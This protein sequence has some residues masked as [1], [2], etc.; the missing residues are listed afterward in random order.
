MIK[1]YENYVSDRSA[2]FEIGDF[3]AMTSCMVLF[4]CADNKAIFY[5]T[6]RSRRRRA[7]AIDNARCVSDARLLLHGTN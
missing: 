3:K 5:E 1:R 4:T 6:A 7:G 2:L